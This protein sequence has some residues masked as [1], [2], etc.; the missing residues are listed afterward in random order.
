MLGQQD[1][2]W[3]ITYGGLH[4][5]V[6]HV[7]RGYCTLVYSDNTEDPPRR[8]DYLVDAIRRSPDQRQQAVNLRRLLEN[9][10]RVGEMVKSSPRSRRLRSIGSPR[11]GF[12]AARVGIL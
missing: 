12:P 6:A 2:L 9:A 3:A 1:I 10:A 5:L 11:F 8:C 7:A 4:C